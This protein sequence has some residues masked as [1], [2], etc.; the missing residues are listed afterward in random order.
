MI[1]ANPPRFREACRNEGS[2]SSARLVCLRRRHG[3]RSGGEEISAWIQAIKSEIIRSGGSLN[4]VVFAESHVVER[5]DAD[6]AIMVIWSQD[7]GA[8]SREGGELGSRFKS[9][10]APATVVEHK[11]GKQPL[12][13]SLGRRHGSPSGQLLSPET[14]LEHRE[15]RSRRAAGR[16]FR[17][18]PT[19]D[20]CPP[21]GRS[22]RSNE[23]VLWE[24][25]RPCSGN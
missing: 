16:Q 4:D 13:I 7:Q 25:N 5:M 22:D 6:P 1:E 11:H 20:A 18:S 15:P 14:S 2:T 3:V 17:P 24:S 19:A 21:A 23:D 9:G 12:G 10:A 8:A